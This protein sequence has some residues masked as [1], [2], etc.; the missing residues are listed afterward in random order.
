VI[1]ITCCCYCLN[2]ESVGNNPVYTNGNEKVGNLIWPYFI[3]KDM[4][5]HPF[6]WYWLWYFMLIWSVLLKWYLDLIQV[7]WILEI[8]V[9]LCYL[10]NIYLKR[11]KSPPLH[12]NIPLL[13][14]VSNFY[15]LLFIM[16]SLH[17]KKGSFYIQYISQVH[18]CW[19]SS[20]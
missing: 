20:Y 9:C 1:S 13:Q 4:V 10:S 12:Q 8:C 15:F 3:W 6:A 14:W 7:S 18:T 16:S 11:K 5:F 2:P 19:S 17:Q